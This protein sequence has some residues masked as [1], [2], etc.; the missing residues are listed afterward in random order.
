MAS[1]VSVHFIASSF[2]GYRKTSIRK[3]LLIT[4]S[5]YSKT[6]LSFTQKITRDYRYIDDDKTEKLLDHIVVW[7]LGICIRECTKLKE[8]K[9]SDLEG[10]GKVG[11]D[12]EKVLICRF[13]LD[14]DIGRKL[15]KVFHT[16]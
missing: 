10:K 1:K 5:H 12:L 8:S 3:F 15:W 7:I 9:P 2:L 13:K 11:L 14:L 4:F 6:K 16:G